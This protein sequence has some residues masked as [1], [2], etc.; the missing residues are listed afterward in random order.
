MATDEHTFQPHWHW[1]LLLLPI[2]QFVFLCFWHD[3]NWLCTGKFSN[4][5]RQW[6]SACAGQARRHQR[7]ECPAGTSRSVYLPANNGTC[8]TPHNVETA[9]GE[10]HCHNL[11]MQSY[12][13]SRTHCVLCSAF[14]FIFSYHLWF[15]QHQILHKV[16]SH[17]KTFSFLHGNTSKHEGTAMS[18]EKAM[19]F[20]CGV[21]LGLISFV[22]CGFSVF[23]ND[24]TNHIRGDDDVLASWPSPD[25][26]VLAVCC[27][28]AH[29]V[30][31][32]TFIIWWRRPHVLPVSAEKKC[33]KVF[34][35]FL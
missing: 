17:V 10:H 3:K 28:S 21:I 31:T 12:R 11:Q 34:L 30:K 26:V 16:F 19:L 9:T 2:S 7:C 25:Q 22:T 24:V 4:I 23:D 14:D 18:R 20:L 1:L 5:N 6:L 33:L 15:Y 35:L 8:S 32:S 27:R 13:Q 29:C